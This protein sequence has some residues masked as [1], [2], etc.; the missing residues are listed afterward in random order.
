ML[1]SMIIKDG[2]AGCKNAMNCDTIPL[3][4]IT[5]LFYSIVLLRRVLHP[6]RKL[7]LIV[8]DNLEGMCLENQRL[9]AK[10]PC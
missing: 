10:D 2:E 3:R 5:L 8:N 7:L 9:R 4:I 6:V 1:W